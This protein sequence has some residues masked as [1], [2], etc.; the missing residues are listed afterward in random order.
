MTTPTT[1][2]PADKPLR[3]S[4]AILATVL[5]VVGSVVIVELLGWGFARLLGL[6][7]TVAR[8][9]ALA[10]MLVL[11]IPVLL[12]LLRTHR[13]AIREMHRAK[14]VQQALF[15]QGGDLLAY[16]D[17]SGNP[18]WLSESFTKWMGW[19]PE[20]LR[21]TDWSQRV[22]PDD[23]E[24]CCK[25]RSRCITRHEGASMTYRARHKNGTMSWVEVGIF[26]LVDEM[27]R[28]DGFVL[29][30]RDVSNVIALHDEL[31]EQSERMRL[32]QRAGRIG[33]WEYVVAEDR[34]VFSELLAEM[35]GLEP[36][37]THTLASARSWVDAQRYEAVAATVTES[38][39]RGQDVAMTVPV[40]P[41]DGRLRMIAL[42]ATTTRDESGRIVRIV[43]TALD[44]T[45]QSSQRDR[46]ALS[47]AT[48]VALI[49]HAP[50]ALAMCDRQLRCLRV[51]RHWN[52]AVGGPEA[53]HDVGQDGANLRE[54]LPGPWSHWERA[55]HS[56]LAGTPQRRGDDHVMDATGKERWLRWEMLPWS[57]VS[58]PTAGVLVLV[59][60]IS[61]L[62][63]AQQSAR[64]A[65]ELLDDSESAARVGSWSYDVASGEVTWSREVYRLFGADETLPAPDYA[66]ILNTYE[67]AS[68]QRLDAA[69]RRAVTERVPYEVVL[70]LREAPKGVRHVSARGR[71]VLSADGSSVLGLIGTV[72]DVTAEVER[73]E[74]L[75]RAREAA[76]R[77][78][79]AKSEFLA[80]MS[81]EIRTPMTAILGY[82]ELLSTD[83][84]IQKDPTRIRSAA[85]TIRNNARHLLALIN[86]ILDLSKIDAGKMVIEHLPTNVG[87]VVAEVLSLLGPGARS[88]GLLLSTVGDAVDRRQVLT[89]PIRLRQVL[90]NL[91]GN[92]I[93]FTETGS[94]V[95]EANVVPRGDGAG[96]ALGQ[97]EIVIRVIDTGIGM[98]GDQLERVFGPFE[99]ADATTSRRFGGTGLGLRISRRLTE[100]LGG[101]LTVQSV[102]GQGSSF[103]VRIPVGFMP[104]RSGPSVV[105]TQAGGQPRPTIEVVA[106]IA[107]VDRRS[108]MP[109]SNL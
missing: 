56:A 35:L 94:V 34:V 30:N 70:Q 17:N 15:D 53:A 23:F 102:P 16:L 5:L 25:V 1:T 104:E 26:A 105:S 69:V 92:A 13:E 73:E 6:P 4:D 99:Q 75:R 39:A 48:L 71:P 96:Q 36:T 33:V 81:H 77:G 80:S 41:P 89:D 55:C 9:A 31:Q 59:E 72:R 43:G 10:T 109:P 18:V 54:L 101:Q 58:L 52:K 86:D 78:N 60:D 66:G 63:S 51:S 57:D 49:E 62:K 27:G 2:G 42:T 45:E 14:R 67:P 29:R 84:E 108:T 64:R 68:A 37:A 87:G 3:A 7:E 40:T 44:V 46:L 106:D 74:E 20:D 21:T 85:E 65:R 28:P 76:E 19:T 11:L 103:T 95:V 79:R 24:R 93:K 32:A 50:V 22:H 83:G 100:L 107:D 88:K 38:F 47:E 8:V 98:S 91:V 82:A 97:G 61:A 12:Y 90:V